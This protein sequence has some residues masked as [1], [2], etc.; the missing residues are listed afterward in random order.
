MLYQHDR[1]GVVKI[2]A[3]GVGVV[4]GQALLADSPLTKLPTVKWVKYPMNSSGVEN[5][6][7]RGGGCLYP[8]KSIVSR[9]VDRNI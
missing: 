5:S 9:S 7:I 3:L 1:V 6:I 8:L 2:L 4:S